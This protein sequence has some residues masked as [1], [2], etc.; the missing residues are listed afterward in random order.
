MHACWDTNSHKKS[1]NQEQYRNYLLLWIYFTRSGY[2]VTSY[3]W[4]KYYYF[5][6]VTQKCEV[7]EGWK[8]LWA[9]SLDVL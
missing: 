3:L 9:G 8:L 7:T 2:W 5:N 4:F 6:W 1:K